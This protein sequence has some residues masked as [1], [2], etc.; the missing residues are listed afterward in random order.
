[1]RPDEAIRDAF[2]HKP[3]HGAATPAGPRF[4]P[5]VRGGDAEESAGFWKGLAE[6]GAVVAPFG[7]SAWAT[8]YGMVRDRFGITWV[9]D[10]PN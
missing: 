9:L 5:A 4:A 7:P 8:A 3:G 6:G 2:G 1:M 10:V